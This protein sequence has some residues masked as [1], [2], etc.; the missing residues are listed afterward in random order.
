MHKP[1]LH[2]TQLCHTSQLYDIVTIM[3]HTNDNIPE[4]HKIMLYEFHFTVVY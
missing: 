2:Q 4:N 1:P 3:P